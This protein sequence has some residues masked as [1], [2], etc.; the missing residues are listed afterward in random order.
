MLQ[1][2]DEHKAVAK[3]AE[4]KIKEAELT[5]REKDS[6]LQKYQTELKEHERNEEEC[7]NSMKALAD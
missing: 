4:S 2:Q 3:V 7:R 1:N 5:V 6:V